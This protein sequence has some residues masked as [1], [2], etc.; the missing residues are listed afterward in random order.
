MINLDKPR[1]QDVY[2]GEGEQAGLVLGSNRKGVC[3]SDDKR[4]RERWK[5][6]YYFAPGR[7]HDRSQ[8]TVRDQAT[9]DVIGRLVDLTPEGLRVAST[10]RIEKGESI[11]ISIQLP[12]EMK[13][14]SDILVRAVCV[15]CMQDEE[16]AEFS[17]GFAIESISPPYVDIIDML[18]GD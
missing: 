3:M 5:A 9:G 18:I 2:Y 17:A 16:T 13:G 10:A 6:H 4:R 15:W 1:A 11:A 14:E 8:F 7:R 12:D